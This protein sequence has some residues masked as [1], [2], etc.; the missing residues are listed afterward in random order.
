MDAFVAIVLWNRLPADLDHFAGLNR[1]VVELEAAK[2]IAEVDDA[3][4]ANERQH[5]ID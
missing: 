4:F 2:I 5:A 1:C 3:A